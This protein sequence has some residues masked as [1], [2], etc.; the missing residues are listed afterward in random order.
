MI[1]L[2]AFHKT[3]NAE[4]AEVRRAAHAQWVCE[5]THDLAHKVYQGEGKSQ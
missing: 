3:R 1:L 4:S 2:T 5:A